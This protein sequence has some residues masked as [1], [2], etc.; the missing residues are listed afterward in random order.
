MWLKLRL[1]LV[2]AAMFAIVYGLVVFAANRIGIS[3]L[4]I[5][6]GILASFMMFIQYML[7]PK[8]VEWSMGVKYVNE[9]EYP[10]L[11]RMVAELARDA[12]IPKPKIGIARIPIPNAFA[13]GRWAKDGRVC[14]TE[15][16]MNLLNERELRAVLAH[17]VS[18]LKHRDV[19]V[20]TMISV[21]PMIAWYLAWNSLFSGGRDRGNNILIGIAAFAVYFLT[22]LLV[23]YVSRI[24]EY[25]ADEG[26][27]KLGN[28]P[29]QL[30]SALYKL[31]YGSAR[32]PK[33]SLKQ[34]EGMK[35]FF[36]SDP[37]R[38]SREIR[39]LSQIDLD[40]SGTIDA[41]E[42]AALRTRPIKVNT[43]DKLMEM[44][45]THPNML[46]RI[47]RLSSLQGV[48]AY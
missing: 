8:M 42:L 31:V 15:G 5:F 13:F 48:S 16:I 6:Y 41:T 44:L 22:N 3:D 20:I 45:S 33:E 14:V 12:R 43:A 9:Q 38:A 39:E 36:A 23:L 32:I 10:A 27:V 47:Q 11:H 19:A 2:M 4:W 29:H 46:K 26:A 24:R 37:S 7:G 40:G 28:S 30:A 21:I 17:E 25:S 1:Y 18:H 34:V 35:A